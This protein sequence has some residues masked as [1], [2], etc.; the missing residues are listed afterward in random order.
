MRCTPILA[1][2][3]LPLLARG[4][5]YDLRDDMTVADV[6]REMGAA[7]I[8]DDRV[9]I[10]G[11]AGRLNVA[12]TELS[13]E[14][15]AQAIRSLFRDARPEARAGGLLFDVAMKEGAVTRF[16]VLRTGRGKKTLVF[17][18]QVPK[19]ALGAD[20]TEHWPDY[21]PAPVN[22]RQGQVVRMRRRGALLVTYSA[23]TTAQALYREYDHL[24]ENAGWERMGGGEHGAFYL[25]PQRKRM[26]VLNAVQRGS[27]AHAAIFARK[28]RD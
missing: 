5:I 4:L 19:A 22:V 18:L 15:A 11:Q 3:L 1:L 26:L 9:S 14:R 12:Y 17:S 27:T 25:G 2:L 21:L 23:N 28:N 8:I 20:P 13:P 6:R 7:E 24:L 10:N 16:L